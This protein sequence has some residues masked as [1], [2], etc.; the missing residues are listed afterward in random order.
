MTKTNNVIFG[1]CFEILPTLPAG[2][3]QLV[4]LDMPY[5][6]TSL[7]FDKEVV[8][9]SRK[10]DYTKQKDR[11]LMYDFLVEKLMPALKRVCAPNAV[12]V[13]TSSK[14]FSAVLNFAWADYWVD[15]AVWVKG[16]LTNPAQAS[17]TKQPAK[18]EL[19]SVFSFGEKYTFNKLMGEGKP[20]KGFRS[21][22]KTTGEV[23]GKMK[24][25]HYENEGTRIQGGVFQYS[26]D[27]GGTHPTQKPLGLWKD[28]IYMYSNENDLVLDCFAGLMTTAVASIELKR[29]YLC[30]ENNL[31]F[32]NKG[33]S[34]VQ[35]I[36]NNLNL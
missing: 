26:R 29:S 30:I 25:I 14:Q 31:E 22:L 12:V 21:D 9:K 24:S 10:L 1:D 7:F 5:G 18:F 19:V 17:K 11:M 20:Y 32:Y 3:V 27:F 13:A 34:R 8:G 36:E 16:N 23:I 6:Y 28:L 2:S 35:A 4:M 33:L 15:E